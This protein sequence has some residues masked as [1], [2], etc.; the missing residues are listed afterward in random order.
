MDSLITVG[1]RALAP[2]DALGALNCI[3]SRDDPPPAWHCAALP[4][5]CL[6]IEH[7][8]MR[9]WAYYWSSEPMKLHSIG[10]ERRQKVT[11]A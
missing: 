10:V 5:P 9:K 2:G 6:A 8:A 11:W 7:V 1:A 4:W 3:A